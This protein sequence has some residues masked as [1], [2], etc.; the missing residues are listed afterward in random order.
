[1]TF[2]DYTLAEGKMYFVK[3][4]LACLLFAPPNYSRAVKYKK[5]S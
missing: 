4:D 1:M 2:T 5:S 3:D